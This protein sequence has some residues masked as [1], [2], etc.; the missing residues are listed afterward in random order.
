MEGLVGR[1]GLAPPSVTDPPTSVREG[2]TCH[3]AAALKEAIGRVEGRDIDLRQVT[4]T[5]VPHGLHLD[6]DLDFRTRRV[7]DVALT[8]T[9]PLLPSLIGNIHHLEMPEIPGEATSFKVDGDLW[10]S[11]RVPPEPD[12]PSPS[13]DDGKA[14]KRQASE[15]E[16]P[17]NVLP[18]QGESPQD[19]PPSEPDPEEIT[20]I[21]FSGDDEPTIHEPQGSSTPRSEQVPSQE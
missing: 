1:L 5:M 18:V 13:H 21:V 2:V 10:G 17:E 20:E 6:Y 14:S 7:E 4:S 16:A 12:I 11:G 9:S 19:Q 15:E 8:L 3:W